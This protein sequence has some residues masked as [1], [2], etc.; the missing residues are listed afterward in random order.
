MQAAALTIGTALIVLLAMLTAYRYHKRKSIYWAPLAMFVLA[1]AVASG[2]GDLVEATHAGPSVVM[3]SAALL[4][5]HQTLLRV[6]AIMRRKGKLPKVYR[7]LEMATGAGY[8]HWV[9]A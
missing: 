8:Y 1:A 5:L 9:D 7:V 2:T 3:A 4:V 6:G